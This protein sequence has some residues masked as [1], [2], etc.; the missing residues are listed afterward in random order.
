MLIISGGR[1]LCKSDLSVSG[2][3]D[4]FLDW[5]RE[6]SFDGSHFRQ[7]KISLLR[8]QMGSEMQHHLEGFGPPKVSLSEIKKKVTPSQTV[9]T[10]VFKAVHL[11]KC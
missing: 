1:A 2:W 4:G 6:W 11:F 9:L 8:L 3:A 5:S 10:M 7:F